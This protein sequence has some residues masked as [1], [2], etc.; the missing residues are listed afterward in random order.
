MARC[1]CGSSCSCSVQGAGLATVSGTGTPNNP[2][3]VTVTCEN[4]RTCFTAG[5]NITI[6]PGGVIAATVDCS[7]VR[8]C[9]SA[10]PGITYNPATGVIGADIS[11]TGGNSLIID[12]S[13]LYVPTQAA[14]SALG[15]GLETPDSGATVRV[16]T[17]A[18][19]FACNQNA[20]AQGVFCNPSTGELQSPPRTGFVPGVSVG[21]TVSFPAPGVATPTATTETLVVS[22]TQTNPTCYPMAVVEYHVAHVT[23]RINEQGDNVAQI[24]GDAFFEWTTDVVGVFEVG[25]QTTKTFQTDIIPAGGSLPYRTAL[26]ELNRGVAGTGRTL[27]RQVTLR[28]FGIT[29]A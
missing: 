11:T 29:V 14:L 28:T 13:G 2:Y 24:D 22:G 1:G 21:D 8:P 26:S 23:W 25:T 18:W 5:D 6:S 12:E 19:P 4:V 16:N 9:L 15:C 27:F 20:N 10:G 7:D 17:A 3:I